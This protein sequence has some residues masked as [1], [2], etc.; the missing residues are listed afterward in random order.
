MHAVHCVNICQDILSPG[1]LLSFYEFEILSE[2]D[3][4]ASVDK[5]GFQIVALQP[6]TTTENV[7]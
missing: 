2:Q 4:E 6:T 5:R 1:H 3:I 7:K